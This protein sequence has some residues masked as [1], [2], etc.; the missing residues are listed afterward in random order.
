[1]SSGRFDVLGELG[2]TR[3]A[4]EGVVERYV[5]GDRLTQQTLARLRIGFGPRREVA[6]DDRVDAGEFFARC[7]VREERK[8]EAPAGDVLVA[9]RRVRDLVREREQRAR[10]VIR[11][12]DADARS[13]AGDG[14]FGVVVAIREDDALAVGNLDDGAACW[15][16]WSS[17]CPTRRRSARSP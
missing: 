12:C 2:A 1:V 4:S 7:D 9:R 14:L 6:I 10:R 3:H 16:R 5:F 17:P 13:A 8:L 11:K 15:D